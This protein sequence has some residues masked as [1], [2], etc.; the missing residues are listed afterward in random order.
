MP[1]FAATIRHVAEGVKG[2]TINAA[3]KNIEGWEETLGKV[4]TPGAKGIVRDLERLKKLI[5][6]DDIDGDAV[7]KLVA[8]LGEETVTMAGRAEGAKAERI[9]ELGEA[10]NSASK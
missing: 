1:Q 5:T 10:L 6:S 2:F 4:E 3:V 8:K 7:K 9:K